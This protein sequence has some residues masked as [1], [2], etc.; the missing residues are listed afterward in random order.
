MAKPRGGKTTSDAARLACGP[1][2][3]DR[4]K[5]GARAGGG[6]RLGIHDTKRGAGVVDPDFGGDEMEGE[7]DPKGGA[8][9]LLRCQ[10]GQRAEGEEDAHDGANGS[11]GQSNGEGANHPLAMQYDLATADVQESLYQ[12]KQNDEGK[13]ARGGC[14]IGSAD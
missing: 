10:V 5:C 6:A 14:L 7:A 2:N 1:G 4:W 13:Q 3:Q 9:E 11:N 8:E 12:G